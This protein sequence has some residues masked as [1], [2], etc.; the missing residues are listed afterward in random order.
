M[1]SIVINLKAVSRKRLWFDRYNKRLLTAGIFVLISAWSI[2]DLKIN[3]IQFWDGIPHFMN[4]VQEMFPPNCKVFV[5]GRV[6]WSIIETISMAFVGTVLGTILSFF[7]GLLAANNLSPFRIV[8]E[9]ARNVMSLERAVPTLV[10]ILVL[11]VAVGLGPFA[12]M[13]AIAV[14]SIGMLGKLFAEA[15]EQID[16]KSLES[17]ESVGATKSQ[18]IRYAV[19]PQVMPSFIANTLYRFDINI[20]TAVFLGVVGGGGIG[21]ELHLAMRLFR[22]PEALVITVLILTVIM[23]AEKTS[24][25]LRKKIIG[26]ELL[27]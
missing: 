14:G 8:R 22:Y 19:L 4:L 15:I 9:I 21:Y 1:R 5:K 13:L 3:P 7:F 18:T 16:P 23:F 6:L 25:F 17:M 27:Q 12:G 26:Q 10:V 11:V 20:R 2:V 24:D